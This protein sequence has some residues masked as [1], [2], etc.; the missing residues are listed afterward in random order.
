MV[1]LDDL[2][3]LLRENDYLMVNAGVDM[4]YPFEV[5]RQVTAELV[6]DP[7]KQAVLA[8]PMVAPGATPSASQAAAYLQQVQFALSSSVTTINGVTDIFALLDDFE[9]YQVFYGVAPRQLRTWV[10]QPNGATVAVLDQNIIPSSSYTDVGYID[11]FLSP[12]EAPSKRSEFLTFKALSVSWNLANSGPWNINPRFYFYIN[13]CYVAPVADASIVQ[14]MLKRTM[15]CHYV[16][17]GTPKVNQ[18]FPK[19]N[20]GGISPLKRAYGD[21]ALGDLANK[22]NSSLY[23]EAAKK[24][25]AGG[26]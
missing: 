24:A 8:G 16:S 18:P 26:D 21:L 4:F 23:T 15:P 1:N 17:M 14:R 3:T 20:Y 6:Y 13:R 7:V 12:Y 25:G 22:L 11:G 5:R 2:D 10:Q 19:A 9:M